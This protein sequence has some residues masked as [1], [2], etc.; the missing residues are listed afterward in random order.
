[1]IV[2]KQGL[3]MEMMLCILKLNRQMENGL[4]WLKLLKRSIGHKWLFH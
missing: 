3:I 2:S 1:M 4:S